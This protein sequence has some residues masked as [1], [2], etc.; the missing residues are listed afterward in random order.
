MTTAA[1]APHPATTESTQHTRISKPFVVRCLAALAGVSAIALGLQ[2]GDGSA[3]AKTLGDLSSVAVPGVAGLACLGRARRHLGDEA[4]WRWLGVSCL[5]WA[6]GGTAWTYYGVVGDRDYPFPSIADLCWIG[7]AMPAAIGLSS[8][9][10]QKALGRSRLWTSLDVATIATAVLFVSWATVLGD[11]YNAQVSGHF[12]RLVGIAYPVVDVVMLTLVLVIAARKAVGGRLPWLILS[13]GFSTLA[14][15]DSVYALRAFSGGYEAGHLF[16]VSWVIAFALVALAAT[17]PAPRPQ[18]DEERH[19]TLVQEL[20]PYLPVL[21]ALA[22]GTSGRLSLPDT[23]FLFWNGILLLGLVAVR[24]VVIIAQKMELTSDLEGR[25]QKRTAE[26]ED[27]RQFLAAVLDSLEEGVVACDADGA[28]TVFNDATRRLHGLP[29]EPIRPDRWTEHFSL[30]Q[31]DGVTPLQTDLIPL[32]RALNGQS[33]RNEELVIVPRDG[34]PRL[35]QSNGRALVGPGGETLGAVVAMNDITD[36]RRAQLDLEYQAFHD[37]LTGLGNRAWFDTG[38]TAMLLR[39]QVEQTSVSLVLVDLDDFKRVNDSLGHM[40]GDLVLVEV[41]ERLRSCVRD[42]DLAVRL[43]GDGFVF[44]LGESAAADAVAVAQRMLDVLGQP[45]TTAGNE[46]LVGASIGIVSDAG[47][48]DSTQLLSAA[49]LAM[50]EAKHTARGGHVLFAPT[51]QVLADARLTLESAMRAGLR[52]GEFHLVYQPVVS[53]STGSITG[54]EALLR[55]NRGGRATV[56]PL[57]FIPVAERT[58]FIVALGEWVLAEACEQLARWD[59]VLPDG[60]RLAMAVNVSLRQLDRPGF[61]DHLRAV[62][63][64]TGV[65]AGRLVLEITET[66]LRDDETTAGLLRKLRE[67]GVK[68]SIDDFGTGYSSLARLRTSAV[69]V[70]KV[71]R[72][73]VAEIN[74]PGADVPIVCATV[75]MARGLGLRSIAEGIETP[76]QFAFLAELGC[77]EGQGYLMSRP[78]TP[79][80]IAALLARP[81][82]SEGDPALARWSCTRTAPTLSPTGESPCTR[83]LCR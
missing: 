32:M 62:L 20:V 12:E 42:T 30:R 13:A 14:V 35:V 82:S 68:L 69:D 63:A 73:F 7:Y 83:S 6:A 21:V 11:L 58:G 38:V 48:R 70:I 15:T 18:C 71:D 17:A 8:L 77:D 76:E 74:G 3:A 51:M 2:T 22:V 46:L 59:S 16:D 4:A 45:M 41:G 25:V 49:H 50:Y 29:A 72:S 36:R 79:D 52:H 75:A 31:P 9:G 55:W 26:L 43:S 27:E 40:I 24:Q 57:E 5:V 54:V 53:L 28:L 1:N 37:R 56:S 78:V 39:A 10:C 61:V 60:Y 66:A 44:A 23:P 47:G 19:L 81:P 64:S 67:V 34:A 33:V 80:A 65:D